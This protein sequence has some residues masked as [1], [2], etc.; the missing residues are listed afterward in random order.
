M[1]SKRKDEHVEFALKQ[2]RFHSDFARIRLV[3]QSLPSFDLDEISLNT[4]YLGHDFKLPIYINAMTGG[5]D[6]TKEINQ[7]LALLAKKYHLAMAVGSQHVALDDA[8]Y[9]ASF[10][11]VRDMY[12]KGFL[13]G[14]INANASV[15][16]AKRAVSMI[17]ANALG[18]HI[19]PAQEL[20]MDEGDRHFKHWLSNIKDIVEQV[21]VPVIVKEVGNG[22]SYETV[23]KLIDVGVK[24]VDVSGRGGTNFIWIENARSEKKRYDY[25]EDWGLTTIEAL[26][27][28]QAHLK[29][30]EVLASGGVQS[31]LDV[32]KCLVLGAKA[33][34][35][36]GMFLK[37][38]MNEDEANLERF[39]QDLK[40]LMILVDVD[41]VEKLSSI[42]YTTNGHL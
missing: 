41:Q 24:H 9:E 11:I 34:G 22:L 33:V 40:K 12:P 17:D 5:S 16:E 35:M 4:T 25:L 6:K 2:D 1:R 31:P 19:N 39:I 26:L 38:V 18:I 37:T 36:S 23:Q 28:N 8:S 10:R 21:G 32:I 20:T 30:V 14:N 3:H 7:R 15:E 13:I 42:R 27:D 29:Q